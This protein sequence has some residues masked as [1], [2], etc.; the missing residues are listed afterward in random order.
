MPAGAKGDDALPTVTV[1]AMDYALT[2]P[3]QVPAGPTRVEVM[4]HGT[5]PHQAALVRLESGRT[6]D[7]YVAALAQSF[8]S[9]AEVGT[10]VGGPNGAE[11][12]ATSEVVADLKPGR[13]LVMC[14]IPSP[15]GAPHLV[16]GM[17]TELEVTESDVP[18]LEKKGAPVVQLSEFQFDVPREFVKA[19]SSGRPV[20][21]VNDGDQA[22]E[23]VVS[24][25]P[26]GVEIEDIVTWNDHALFTPEPFPQPQVDVAGVTML[27][28]GE[29][30]RVR[31]DLPA[32]D[33]VLLCFLPDSASGTSHLHQ[34][35]VYPFTVN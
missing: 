28:A 8:E 4:N 7:E 18:K 10:F 17:I 22:H 29:R 26:D 32:G 11:P 21:V 2:A 3:E 24:R 34:G 13:H 35:M 16:K 20:E 15:D 30:G 23:L 33:Y 1:M 31:L 9:A 6:K 27:D 14:L 12:G 25:L 19:V 5:E